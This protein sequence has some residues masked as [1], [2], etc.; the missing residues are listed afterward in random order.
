MIAVNL[1]L[2]SQETVGEL[3]P[4]PSQPTDALLSP[5][6]NRQVAEARFTRQYV[7]KTTC[8]SL[9]THCVFKVRRH[10]HAEF[11]VICIQLQTFTYSLST[12]DQALQT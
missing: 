4:K 8:K 3:S 6:H 12:F 2:Q 11:H 9:L 10:A 7:V 5:S 1:Q